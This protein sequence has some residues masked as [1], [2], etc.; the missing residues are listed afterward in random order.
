[1]R[2]FSSPQIS[3]QTQF[4]PHTNSPG[5]IL[6]PSAIE[7]FLFNFAKSGFEGFEKKFNRSLT[8]QFVLSNRRISQL[9]RSESGLWMM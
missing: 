4:R 2:D 6:C 9:T 5:I 8:E 3:V 1:M 7:F